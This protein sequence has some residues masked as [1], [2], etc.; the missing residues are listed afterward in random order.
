[1]FQKTNVTVLGIIENMSSFTSDDGKEHFI[2]GKDGAKKMSENLNIDLLGT[3][4]IE[5]GLREGADKG[6][7]YMEFVNDSQHQ[8]KYLELLKRFQK[9]LNNLIFK[10]KSFH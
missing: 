6:E 1:M 2:F 8:T 10:L 9:K 7:P 4:P 5:I 3:I